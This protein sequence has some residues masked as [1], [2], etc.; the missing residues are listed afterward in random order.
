ML[1]SLQG[2]ILHLQMQVE[3]LIT[4]NTNRNSDV[5]SF[6]QMN[7]QMDKIS[8]LQRENTT[9]R[10]KMRQQAKSKEKLMS[11][12]KQNKHKMDN[13]LE[14]EKKIEKYEFV[15]NIE[16]YKKMTWNKYWWIV[17]APFPFPKFRELSFWSNAVQHSTLVQE[18]R[19]LK[20]LT[21]R[22]I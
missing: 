11:E 1:D 13:I 2:T 4:L 15:L 17:T 20:V 3:L 12:M 8:K 6:L 21:L 14:L 10:A 22:E 9:I 19:M 7:D 18:Y 16:K 5:A